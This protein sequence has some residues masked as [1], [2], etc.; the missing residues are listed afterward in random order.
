MSASIAAEKPKVDKSVVETQPILPPQ[1]EDA[2]Q[3]VPVQ[4]TPETA[5]FIQEV[6]HP[7]VA[8]TVAD[9]IAHAKEGALA[10]PLPTVVTTLGGEVVTRPTQ[11]LEQKT[12]PVGELLRRYNPF[13]PIPAGREWVHEQVNKRQGR[14]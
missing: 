7:A 1:V 8:T 5:P 6:P 4:K 9:G 10:Q 12:H 13:A 14:T 2:A 3:Y 11:I